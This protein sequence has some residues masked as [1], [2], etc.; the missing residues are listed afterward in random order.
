MMRK[1][2]RQPRLWRQRP[3]HTFTCTS[4]RNGPYRKAR[5]HAESGADTIQTAVV[6]VLLVILHAAIFADWL[7]A[8][9]C[10]CSVLS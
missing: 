10:G 9:T 7:M 5:G 2:T 3:T 6:T 8:L 1:R 4:S